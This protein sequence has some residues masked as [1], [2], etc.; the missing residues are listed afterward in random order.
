MAVRASPV[1]PVSSVKERKKNRQQTRDGRRT[2]SPLHEFGLKFFFSASA[3]QS[4]ASVSCERYKTSCAAHS[5]YTVTEWGER[6]HHTHKHYAP[7]YLENPG[8]PGKYPVSCRFSR[9]RLRFCPRP[10]LTDSGKL[11]SC[12]NGAPNTLCEVTN[13]TLSPST[14]VRKCQ[15]TVL[16]LKPPTQRINSFR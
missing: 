12:Q 8:I 11:E 7:T 1:P 2:G 14:E 16:A 10:A 13:K 4:R 9:F 6:V 5:L 3:R 15:V